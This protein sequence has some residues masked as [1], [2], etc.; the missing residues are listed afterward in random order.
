MVELSGPAATPTTGY[1]ALFRAFIANNLAFVLADVQ[2]RTA[3]TEE[4]RREGLAA[5]EYGLAEPH[6]RTKAIA[7]LLALAPHMLGA[8]LREAWQPFLERGLALAPDAVSAGEIAY[9]LGNIAQFQGRFAQ[10]EEHF[11]DSAVDLAR[12]GALGKHA[13]SLNR[14][15]F[16][17]RHRQRHAEA[18]ALA[19]QALGLLDRREPEWGYS[20]FVLGAV[21]FDQQADQAAVEHLQTALGCWEAHGDDEHRADGLVNLAPALRRVQRYDEAIVALQEAGHLYAGRR[22]PRRQGLVQLNL[23]NIHLSQ[24]RWEEALACCREA[25]PLFRQV[26]DRLHQAINH[27]NMGVACRRLQRLEQAERLFLLA[28][29]ALENF[30][31]PRHHANALD[32]LGNTYRDGGRIPEAAAAYRQALARLA[33][34]PDPAALQQLAEEVRGHLATLPAG[35]DRE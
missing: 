11:A 21:A 30:D 25:E 4:Q 24:A 22:D 28:I 31:Q 23:S 35:G 6:T 33:R 15:A 29:G 7:L 20:H 32:G 18:Q 17:L 5:L 12:A 27:N 14:L 34:A 2:T 16:V 10:A 13:R 8:G 1:P 26:G 19:L 9:H 3:L